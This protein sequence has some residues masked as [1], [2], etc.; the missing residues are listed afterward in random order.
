MY[1]ERITGTG[2][3]IG[4][5][6]VLV[7]HPD[8]AYVEKDLAK[9]AGTALSETNRQMPD[10]VGSGL[11]RLERVGKTKLYSLNRKHFLVPALKRLFKDLNAVY[12]DASRK[13]TE[14]AVSS[15]KSVEA[16][17][18]FGSVAK[19]KV[20]SDLV[21]APSD[22]DLVFVL[23][24]ESEKEK[25]FDS[26]VS[27]INNEI[28]LAYGMVCYPVVMTKAEYVEALERKDAFI[29]NVQSE[30]VELHGRKPRRFG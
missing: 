3:K 30:G 13:I 28:S 29:L 5:L 17:I 23:K 24:D 15:S 19:R 8:K 14:F 27:Y 22:I 4:I 16:V 9:A 12:L 11:V 6:N 7:N 25:L 10:L 1:L 21:K 20:K 26:L 2:T 18:L